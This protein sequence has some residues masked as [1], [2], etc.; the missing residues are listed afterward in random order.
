MIICM[1]TGRFQTESPLFAKL[2]RTVISV[3][4]QMA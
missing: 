2:F 3:R 4:E 1:F